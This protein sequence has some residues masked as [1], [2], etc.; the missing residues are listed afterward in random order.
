MVINYKKIYNK[1]FLMAAFLVVLYLAYL[2]IKPYLISIFMSVVMAYL[3]YPIYEWLRRIINSQ[4]IRAVIMIILVLSGIV[5]PALLVIDTFSEET[6]NILRTFNAED[7]LKGVEDILKL[8]PSKPFYTYIDKAIDI[9]SLYLLKKA[10]DLILELP[11]LAVAFFIFMF[12]LYYFF[13]HG[14]DVFYFIIPYLPLTRL[15]RERF[16]IEIK[17]T[18]HAIVYG[19]LLGSALQ[20]IISA[21]SF[22]IFDVKA[23][24]LFGF[25]IAIVAALPGIGPAIIWLPMA[26]I[27]FLS[28][29]YGNAIG[30]FL[31]G[32]IVISYIEVF[33]RPKLI[34][35][36]SGIHPAIILIGIL[37]GFQVFGFAGLLMGPL[38]LSILSVFFKIYSVR[39]DVNEIKGE[40]D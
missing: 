10:R 22:Y 6:E 4:S 32:L 1:Y 21:V 28:G 13:T 14:K 11:K 33:L 34:G 36:K 23:P 24:I 40:E 3:L 12:S 35:E 16:I 38:V 7:V 37:G 17:Q 29:E 19:V 39:G 26:I 31:V 8:I 25:I 20:G 5:L 27:K 2:I 18:S 15:H 9:S 30:I